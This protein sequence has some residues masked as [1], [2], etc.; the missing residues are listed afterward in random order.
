M[1]EVTVRRVPFAGG[2]ARIAPL[3]WG[4]RTT[5]DD[6]QHYLPEVKPFFVLS[7]RLPIPAGLRLDDV[8]GRLGVLMERHES[9]RSR[10][11]P[12]TGFPSVGANVV[13]EVL[14]QGSVPLTVV[15]WTPDDPVDFETTVRNARR[16]IDTRLVDHA[17]ESPIRSCLVS[18]RGTPTLLLIGVSH[19]AADARAIDLLAAELAGLLEASASGRATPPPWTSWHP[20]DQA[21]YEQSPQGMLR[22]ATALRRLRRQLDL[23]VP[24][25]FGRPQPPAT[26]PGHPRFVCARLES[27]AIPPALRVLSRRCRTGT[28]AVLLAATAALTHAL[29][30]TERCTFA[31]VLA[32]RAD[33]VAQYAIT[34][35][36][37]TT[38]VTLDP[39]G[40][41]FAE[42]AASA[43]AAIGDATRH[44]LHDPRA[45]AALLRDV[46]DRRGVTFDPSCRFN[47]MWAWTR[48]QPL[49][50]LPDL[51]TIRATTSS[52]TF[53]W[54]AGQATD[55]D[56]ITVSI[57]IH[58]TAE[59][60][61]IDILADTF[62]LP[63]PRLRTLLIG[64][65][66]LLVELVARDVGPKEVAD[67]IAP[68]P[69][70]APAATGGRIR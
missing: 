16:T 30:G 50:D 62:R 36:S 68:D 24:S 31:L 26:D 34:S 57:N 67:L 33:P 11:R 54:P 25:M 61:V 27:Q 58:G 49:P 18:R 55:N 59:R 69:T 2:R 29:V 19:V 20:A 7:R 13:Q 48:K 47:D 32:N 15:D 22:N 39:A 9:L 14:P 8:I 66:R 43:G 53:S 6:M 63:K 44:G 38:W 56:R 42:L 10:Y 70:G 4:Q 46:G 64:Y 28:S 17:R 40:H 45:A 21:A 60:I 5:W 1:G 35:L 51:R 3:A 37:Q 41:T 52:T 65:E 23:A 12:I